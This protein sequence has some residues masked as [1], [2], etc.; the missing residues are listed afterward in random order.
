MR[1][2]LASTGVLLTI[3]CGSQPAEPEAY[4]DVRGPA[5]VLVAPRCR[6]VGAEV[7]CSA[8][9]WFR[10]QGR[11]D[12]TEGAAWIVSSDPFLPEPSDVAEVRRA[13]VIAPLKRGE[14]YI[15]LNYRG[16]RAWAPY[17][18]RVEPGTAPV[19][20]A[21]YLT[22]SAGTRDG[23]VLLEILDGPDAGRQDVSRWNTFWIRHV[24][25]GVPF[26][27]RASK[28]GYVTETQ[29][30]PGIVDSGTGFPANNYIHFSLQP[31]R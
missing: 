15:Q 17:S 23:G 18:Y 25:L 11:L 1:K 3:A 29:R 31:V 26:T 22:G 2:C 27:V 16:L 21:P 8:E 9:A 7:Q 13:G 10:S 20:L 12:V 24:T 28:A 19:A 5:T 6:P 30:H 4:V 14:I